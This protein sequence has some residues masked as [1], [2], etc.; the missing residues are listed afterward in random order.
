MSQT[1]GEMLSKIKTSCDNKTFMFC[2]KNT[3]LAR[4]YGR[5]K[6]FTPWESRVKPVTCYS[7]LSEENES[8]EFTSF[9]G[10]DLDSIKKAGYVAFDNRPNLTKTVVKEEYSSA[11]T[12]TAI[13][14]T[15]TTTTKYNF[16]GTVTKTIEISYWYNDKNYTTPVEGSVDYP[17]FPGAYEP[18]TREETVYQN[19]HNFLRVFKYVKDLTNRYYWE[20]T[21]YTAS[22]RIETLSSGNVDQYYAYSN[23]DDNYYRKDILIRS[24]RTPILNIYYKNSQGVW[25]DYNLCIRTYPE[26]DVDEASKIWTERLKIDT[27]LLPKCEYID[28]DGYIFYI[29]AADGEDVYA[30]TCSSIELDTV[31]T[32]NVMSKKVEF[33][34]DHNTDALAFLSG[35]LPPVASGFTF[36]HWSWIKDGSAITFT[37]NKQISS[38]SVLEVYAV[39]Y[40]STGTV[41]YEPCSMSDSTIP[42]KRRFMYDDLK[43]SLPEGYTKNQFLVWLNGAF[44]PSTR[45][46][47]YENIMYLENAMTMIN[48]K[49]VNQKLGAEVESGEYGTVITKEENDEYR[50]DVNL[51]LFG[52]RGVKVS[53][54][55]KPSSSTTTPISYNFEVIRPLKTLTFPVNVNKN[56]H[57]IIC[58]GKVLT[59][60]EY[61]VDPDNPKTV[62]LKNIEYECNTLLDQL[63]QE[64]DDNLEYYENVNP[65]HLLRSMVMERTYSLVNFT[66]EDSSKELYLRNSNACAIDFPKKGEIMFSR[67]NIGDLVL[68]NGLFEPYLWVHQNTIRF[69]RM[70]SSYRDGEVDKLYH[71]NVLRY[72]F[73]LKNK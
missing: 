2:F 38:G 9:G 68:I 10:Y 28:D 6:L 61:S 22:E 35:E 59:P 1:V 7:F 17:V 64:I 14:K 37:N 46:A 3:S 42:W 72:Y 29:D 26:Y 8:G 63:V 71:E 66:A 73:L 67:L 41:L 13:K 21:P 45:D 20:I 51:R 16:N 12:S 52:W 47:T 48:S 15:T 32:I 53:S 36:N 54:F 58:N 33:T 24:I 34:V 4:A 18:A 40:R 25:I 27:S 69:P 60:D 11:S 30:D 39:Y 65:L 56:A 5:T 57:L 44:V 55:Y 23:E 19:N 62:I 50:Y 49:S 31:K 43:V 70:E